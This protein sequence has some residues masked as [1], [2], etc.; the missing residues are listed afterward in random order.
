M[1]LNQNSIRIFLSLIIVSQTLSY[2]SSYT[3]CVTTFNVAVQ[4]GPFSISKLV[5]IRFLM[6][7]LLF[8]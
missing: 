8:N 5:H 6:D 3:L 7:L 4:N 2:S 1:I